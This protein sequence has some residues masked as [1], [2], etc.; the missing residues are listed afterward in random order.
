[1][2]RVLFVT[3]HFP[4]VGGAGVQRSVKFVRYLPEL[5]W[6]PVV[7]TG[8]GSAD[9]RWTPADESLGGEV[10]AS[11]TV[12]RV[13][14][15]APGRSKGTRARAERWLRLPTGFARWW[16]V[17]IATVGR[18]AGDVDLVFASMSPFESAPAV[19]ELA[20]VIGRPWVADLRDPWALDEMVVHPTA[21]HRRLELAR[22]SR[23]LRTAAAVIVNTE[24]ARS[25]FVRLVPG[26]GAD[27]VVAIP[28]GYDAAD[29]SGPPP[30][31]SDDAFRIVHAGYLHTDLGL[32]QRRTGR[33]R[34]LLGGDEAE[35]DHLARSHVF[36][37]R[38]LDRLLAARPELSDTVELH[39]AGVL[40]AADRAAIESELHRPEIVKTLGY[41]THAETVALLRS[42]DLLFLPMHGLPAG[43]RAR[44]VPGK[45]YEYLAAGRPILAAVPEGDARDLLEQ[46]GALLC[47]PAAVECLQAALGDRIDAAQASRDSAAAPSDQLAP[48]ERRALTRTLAALFDRVAARHAGT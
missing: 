28:N 34:R 9:D 17:G 18:T 11:T 16:Q 44:I 27:R 35:V 33:L 43:R 25:A 47:P 6:E 4:P 31:R 19:A 3:Y 21:L 13:P 12:L 10:P 38:A 24:E 45:T 42:A 2:K 37:L 48:Y 40:S 14:G 29:F 41:L 22:M 30:A 7:L 32:A 39:L 36:L 46:A 26:L 5:G 15:A 1:M 8:P 20:R 23:L